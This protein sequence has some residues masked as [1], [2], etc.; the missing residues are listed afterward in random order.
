M[1]Y[2]NDPDKITKTIA[3]LYMS[4][5]GKDY[6]SGGLK[7]LNKENKLSNLV[8]YFL[9]LRYLFLFIYGPSNIDST[10]HIDGKRYFNHLFLFTTSV[11]GLL[12]FIL[13]ALIGSFVIKINFL[14]L[15]RFLL[16]F[17]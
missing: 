16:R 11:K 9:I 5:Y 15:K 12:D 4:S 6:K 1:D 8:I 17:K 7:L 14:I 13:M 2:H 3:L 10:Y